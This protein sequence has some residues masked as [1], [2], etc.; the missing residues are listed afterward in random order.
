MSPM[1]DDRQRLLDILEAANK[2]LDHAGR[3][4]EVFLRDE[5][6]QVWIMHHLLIIGE[7]AANLSQGVR[8]RH[9]GTSWRAAIAMRNILVHEYFGVDLEQVW[10][11][12]SRSLPRLKRD[13]EGILR[14]MEP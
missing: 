1:R 13:V 2:I 8:E 10:D 11:A 7:A 6:L 5:F 4:K 14:G 3:G 9:P 12:V